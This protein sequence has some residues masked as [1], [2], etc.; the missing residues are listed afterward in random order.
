MGACPLLK[1][2]KPGPDVG[3]A[4]ERAISVSSLLNVRVPSNISRIELFLPSPAPVCTQS[5][6]VWAF[7]GLLSYSAPSCVFTRPD[8]RDEPSLAGTRTQFLS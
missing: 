8:P 2:T 5:S 6:S 7:K 3:Y 1:G 4:E